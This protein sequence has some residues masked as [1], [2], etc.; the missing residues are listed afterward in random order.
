MKIMMKIK[1]DLNKT[2]IWPIWPFF[3][4]SGGILYI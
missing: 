2:K 4:T 1:F 3:D